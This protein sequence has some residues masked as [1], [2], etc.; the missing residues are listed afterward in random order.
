MPAWKEA[1]LVET[2][3]IEPPGRGRGQKEGSGV[4]WNSGRAGGD[5]GDRTPDLSSA[6]AAL[7]HLSY[8][9]A[10][11]ASRQEAAP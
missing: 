11:R 3:G 5:E 6:I 8:V 10:L 2:R 4:R 9:P 7:S 1:G